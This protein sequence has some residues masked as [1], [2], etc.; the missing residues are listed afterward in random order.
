MEEKWLLID[1]KYVP[2][3]IVKSLPEGYIKWN[4]FENHFPGKKCGVKERK[5]GFLESFKKT[6]TRVETRATKNS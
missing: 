5:P 6:I 2:G 3:N 4:P 1:E